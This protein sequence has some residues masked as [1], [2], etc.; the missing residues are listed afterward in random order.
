MKFNSMIALLIKSSD[1]IEDKTV[2]LTDLHLREF[3]FRFHGT[4][5]RDEHLDEG[6]KRSER[7][8]FIAEVFQRAQMLITRNSLTNAST[9]SW[10]I[11]HRKQRETFN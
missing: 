2:L 5:S 6:A 7:E 3:S 8:H 9:S 4:F 1:K 10:A 11:A